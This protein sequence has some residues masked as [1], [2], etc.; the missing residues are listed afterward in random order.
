[1]NRRT[2]FL[3]SF[4]IAGSLFLAAPARAVAPATPAVAAAPSAKDAAR[5]GSKKIQ[6]AKDKRKKS[7]A[8]H[9]DYLKQR[10]DCEKKLSAL[11]DQVS[12][13]RAQAEADEEEGKLLLAQAQSAQINE[14]LEKA[15]RIEEEADKDDADALSELA[16]A[17]AFEDEVNAHKKSIEELTLREK[18]N[19]TVA[20]L[21]KKTIEALTKA[22]TTA[23]KKAQDVRDAVATR[24]KAVEKKRQD[25]AALRKAAEDAA[26]KAA[27]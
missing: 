5:L 25:A 1:M 10:A 9:A 27:K 8:L 14:Q 7:D 17:Q 26:E 21:Y 16:K 22:Q 24:L 11:R 2:P 19:P 15:A 18:A 6:S 4:A 12:A 13:A 23:A 20:G 3:L